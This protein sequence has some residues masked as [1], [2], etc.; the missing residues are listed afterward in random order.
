MVKEYSPFTP[1]VPV[2]IDFF[3][4]RANEINRIIQS[5][6]KSQEI[7][8]LERI[9][10]TGERGIGKSSLCRFAITLAERDFDVIGLHVYLGGVVSLEE[11]VRR[12]FERLLKE[13][14]D[15]P[16]Y[17]SVE[18]F[19]GNHI[20][21]V[22]LFGITVEF[23]PQE[24][25]L[26]RAV[27]DFVP[28]MKNLLLQLKDRKKGILLVLDDINGL[29][30]SSLFAHWLKSVIDEIATGK[31][32]LPFT[33]VL[34]GLPERRFEL[35]SNQPSLDRVFDLIS[36]GK[37]TDMESEEFY[38]KIFNRVG[39]TLEPKA[40]E[41]M[42]RYSGGYP[43]LMHE[44]GDAV[45]QVDDDNLIS[46]SDAVSGIFSAAEIIGAKYIEPKISALIKS[47]TYRSI[48]KKLATE[49][50]SYP[51][52][53]NEVFSKLNASEQKGFDNFIHRM[54]KLG[55]IRQNPQLGMG[56]YEFTREIFRL[57]FWMLERY[58]NK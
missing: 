31:E 23:N 37:F 34:V 33:F 41:I 24:G 35:I 17:D 12:I 8:T 57:Y 55:A 22:G 5:A 15:K 49:K 50:L 4:G 40:I 14:I 18:K 13:S 19:L 25:E 58:E 11:M 48:L 46:E 27:S 52:I 47:K 28:A 44:I 3:V 20:Q 56:S 51:Y 42:Y 6:K 45:F 26:Y 21:K 9:F 32:P 10:V 7:G 39:A 36:I 29:A 38:T 54:K 43:F 2:P 16:W 1:G 30:S 53:K